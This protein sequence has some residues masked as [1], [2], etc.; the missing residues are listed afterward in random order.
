MHWR[1]TRQS[2]VSLFCLRS[3]SGGTGIKRMN[4]LPAVPARHVAAF[5]AKVKAQRRI[6]GSGLSTRPTRDRRHLCLPNN[7]SLA[8][9]DARSPHRQDVCATSLP[10]TPELRE[11]GCFTRCPS[12]CSWRIS[13]ADEIRTRSL[14]LPDQLTNQS[15]LSEPASSASSVSAFLRAAPSEHTGTRHEP[16]AARAT[17]VAVT[18][19]GLVQMK[20]I[21]AT[22]ECLPVNDHL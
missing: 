17:P 3:V 12:L 19:R 10:A 14:I 4:F 20:E 22:R 8:G 9:E 5:F 18:L 7:Q 13:S 1:E 16:T 6:L 15:F 11:S 21:I 2:Q